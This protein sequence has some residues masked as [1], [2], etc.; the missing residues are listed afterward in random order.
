[1]PISICKHGAPFV[2]QHENRYGSGAS[3]SSSLF[4]SIRHISNSHEAINF[5]SCYSA[6]GSCFSNAQM[7]ANASGS[8]VKRGE[9]FKIDLQLIQDNQKRHNGELFKIKF[10]VV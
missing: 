9:L 7:L 6:N 2:V 5:I 3:Q 8:P 4:K 10:A 1:M